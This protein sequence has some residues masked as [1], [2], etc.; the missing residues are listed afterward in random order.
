MLIAGNAN[1]LHLPRPEEEVWSDFTY[2]QDEAVFDFEANGQREA[3]GLLQTAFGVEIVAYP[4]NVRANDQRPRTARNLTKIVVETQLSSSS[5]SS[6][7]STWVAG[8]IVDTAC[9]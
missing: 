3:F 2:R 1:V 5:Q 7:K 8:W 9:L 6:V 4:A